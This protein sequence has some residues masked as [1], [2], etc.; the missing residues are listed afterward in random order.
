MVNR[1]GVGAVAA[2]GR[3]ALLLGLL[4]LGGVA[5]LRHDLWHVS[6]P[7]GTRFSSSQAQLQLGSL[8]LAFEPN[9]GQTDSQVRFL[10][11]P[12]GYGLF[13]TQH[14]A[15]LALPVANKESRSLG[16]T[17]LRMQFADANPAAAV[18]AIE[19]LPGHTNYL[20]GNDASRW[21]TNVPQFARVDYRDLYPGVDLAFYGKQGR[22]EYDFEVK[23]GADPSRVHLRLAGAK[24]LRLAGNGDLLVAL[25]GQEL[26]FL[27]PHL[28][29]PSSAG[30]Q[31]VSG[32]FVLRAQNEVGF[33]V[34]DYDR[35][36]AL[37]IDPVLTFST[38]FGGSG[39]ESCAAIVGA[40]F[41]PHCPA[42]AID[43]ANRAY[44]AGA[45][46]SANGFPA[47]TS[48]I[49]SAAP[50][51]GN[52]DVFVA[53]ISSNG[54]ALVLDQ[55]AFVG[56]SG[57]DYP[58]GV[59]VDSGFN[60]YLAG[61]TSSGDFP[62]TSTG[63]QTSVPAAGNHIFFTELNPSFGGPLYSTF[64]AGN[65]VDTASDMAVDSQG[66]AYLIGTTTSTTTS[67][68]FP[69]TIGSLQ[70]SALAANQF[71]FSKL[72]PNLNGPNS[73]LYSTFFG[74]SAPANG[75]VTGGGITIDANLNVYLAGG[76]NFTD[77]PVVNAFQGVNGGGLDVW[78]AKLAAPANNTQQYTPAFETYFGSTGDEVA[79]GVASDSGN[80]NMYITGSTTST[81]IPAVT[82]APALQASYGGGSSD[83]FLTKF[84]GITT[85]GTTQGS[86]P[87][88]YFTYLGGTGQDVGL[89]V[90]SDTSQNARIAGLTTSGSL[91]NPN[92]LFQ[93]PGGGSDAFFARILTTTTTSTTVNTSSTSILGGS[94]TD[95]G[96]S[97]A[98]DAAL[99]SYI[100]G[101]TA[102]NNFPHVSDPAV[103][104]I[105]PLQAGLGGAS[106]AF[107]S[108]IGPTFTGLSFACTGGCPTPTPANPTVNPSPVGVGN[109][110]TFTY[111]IYNTGDPVNGVVFTDSVGP[112]SVI[113]SATGTGAN[114]AVSG[115]TEVCNLGTVAT[116]STSGSPAIISPATTVSIVVTATPP[117]P[118]TPPVKPPA[119]GNSAVLSV[120][121]T[122][123]QATA[124]GQAT[125]NDFGLSV[126]GQNTQTVTAGDQ[127]SYTLVVT[128]TGGYPESVSLACGALQ[129]GVQCK[130][131][132]TNPITNLSN[133]AQNRILDVTTTPRVTTPASLLRSGPIYA[134][135]L[136][137]SGFA[138]IGSGL[139]R[140]RRWLM[141]II[142]GVLLSGV[143]LQSACSNTSNTSTTTG[144]PAGTYTITVNATSG[145]ATRTTAVTLNVK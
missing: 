50:G 59:A 122:S 22:L 21:V 127:G 55:L 70:P 44:L 116:S 121:G 111:S 46:S 8:P 52:S 3:A 24:N 6:T 13:L 19:P 51:G 66:R 23:P 142:V 74:G 49:I 108:K 89:S 107:V 11:H 92:P 32:G 125:V 85:T 126:S 16:R 115:T 45:T 39:A 110:V 143:A 135:W 84:G 1:G 144:T 99:N 47:P 130:F 27:A 18:S 123:F 68:P 56:G 53:R 64:L 128:P 112:N 58:V 5:L 57:A 131:Q 83:A 90:V 103:P 2:R 82:T 65:G 29:Q 79:Y 81:G 69:T 14:E 9:Q 15:V 37:I 132:G 40:Q 100:A 31:T 120:A 106:D 145:S 42:I 139:S 137:I 91:P 78:A 95:I 67:T 38:Y 105:A 109:T 4:T 113:S 48:P 141:A 114:C 101:E 133:G 104:N 17:A 119:I 7:M 62:T 140:R 26:R 61:N 76:T 33:E 28:Y 73:L 54:S 138:L 20:L 63:Y 10:A 72:N 36:R 43:S 80:T 124:S 71:F 88:L 117:A 97:V 30:N 87:L 118:S 93:S 75:V 136:P 102:S 86:V 94:G 35:S 77:M 34:G 12:S 60:V 41:V 98:V 96:T 25:E 134:F 129:A